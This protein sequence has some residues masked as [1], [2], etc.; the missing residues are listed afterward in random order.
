MSSPA[1]AVA[2]PA[3]TQPWWRE[4][5]RNHWFVFAMA[6][7]AWMFDCLDQQLFIQARDSAV[8]AL[9]PGA[10]ALQLKDLGGMAQS[11][12]VAGWALG[13][14]I[15]GAVGDRIGRAKTL[16]LTVLLYS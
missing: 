4:L 12:F 10:E 8:K 11:I 6:C 5:T 2:V 3:V 14:L 1:S 15:F 16:A 13:G 7:L 9:S